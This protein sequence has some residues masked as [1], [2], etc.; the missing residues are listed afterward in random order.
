MSER[1]RRL[2]DEAV[3]SPTRKVSARLTVSYA[4]FEGESDLLESLYTRGIGDEVA[5]DLYESRHA[6]L[7]DARVSGAVA[8]R[9]LDQRDAQALR[10]N[11]F[12]RMIRNQWVR[13]GDFLQDEWIAA[14]TNPALRPSLGDTALPIF[15]GVD[16]STK[17]DWCA[18]VATAYD[19]ASQKV[20]LVRHYVWKPTPDQPLDFTNT[21]ERAV[22]GAAG[23]FL[24]SERQLRSVATERAGTA[25]DEPAC[26]W[27]NIPTLGNLT[28]MGENLLALFKDGNIEIYGDAD[29]RWSLT[30]AVGIESARGFKI[31]KPSTGKKIDLV[32]ALA[33][34]ALAAV[35]HN[36]AGFG[37]F[38]TT[39]SDR[40]ESSTWTTTAAW[41][42]SIRLRSMNW[43]GE[44]VVA[45]P[46]NSLCTVSRLIPAHS[47][48]FIRSAFGVEKP[49][50]APE[51]SSAHDTS[52]TGLI[53]RAFD[54]IRRGR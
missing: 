2:W 11:Q 10:P 38:N 26:Q 20:R 46:A 29:L 27:R 22:I 32:V 21:I 30:N 8:E 15:V 1:S 43:S 12:A 23:A 51:T 18:V 5:P 48:D 24:D 45:R 28:A 47:V 37:I 53:G 6:V 25:V 13:D 54:D 19:D 31:G 42:T 33:M 16:A 35:R 44:I 41:L 50:A 3:P 9:A 17:H 7:L 52:F 4:G 14:C 34:S 36:R 39:A 49:P 40:L